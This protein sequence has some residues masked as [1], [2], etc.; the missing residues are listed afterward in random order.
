MRRAPFIPDSPDQDSS[1]RKRRKSGIDL[2]SNA[3][4]RFF[5]KLTAVVAFVAN[6]VFFPTLFGVFGQVAR[7][8]SLLYVSLAGL[9][10]GVVGG[11]AAALAGFL[12]NYTILKG[13]G[14]DLESAPV[15]VGASLVIGAVV[16]LLS[17]LSRRLSSEL[18][19]K[20]RVEEELRRYRNGLEELVEA[21]TE[22][23]KET[24][25]K[26]ELEVRERIEALKALHESEERFR[27]LSESTFEGVL[28]FRQQFC[29]E[30][31][32]VASA[33]LERPRSE[34]LGM[35]VEALFHPDSHLS[36]RALLTED[37][38]SPVEARALNGDGRAFPVEARSGRTY[39]NGEAVRVLALR[40]LSEREHARMA[41]AVSEENYRL[42]V[43]NTNEAIL[44]IQGGTIGFV[45]PAAA[46]LLGIPRKELISS[47]IAAFIHPE[48]RDVMSRRY[49][50]RRRGEPQ[51]ELYE[52]R[53]VD[54][55]G[56][57][58]WVEAKVVVI[59]WEG[60]EA[61]LSFVTDVTDRVLAQK[62]LHTSE[63]TARTL[64]NASTTAA[65]L[66]D[67]SGVLLAG[68]DRAFKELGKP[69][70]EVKGG[71]LYRFLPP[72][73]VERR[74]G[75]GRQVLRTGKPSRFLDEINGRFMDTSLYPVFDERRKVVRLA[76]FSTDI[77]ERLKSE[78]A[79]RQSEEKYSSVFST[80]PVWI[81]I[82]TIEEGRYVEVNE[83]FLTSTGY[84]REEVLGRTALELGMWAD[85]EDRNR[86]VSALKRDG[87]VRNVEVCR[88][89]KHG[90]LLQM[91]FF[92]D[93]IRIGD[94]FYMMSISLDITDRKRNEEERA[95]LEEQLLQAQKMEA[96]GV[97][98]GGIAHDFNNLLQSIRGYAELLLLDKSA[99][100]PGCRE[101]TEIIHSASRGADMV[102]QLLTFSRK[103]E[104]KLR[105]VDLNREIRNMGHVLDR[106]LH[107]M[108]R[109]SLHLAE[110][111][112]PIY[113]DPVQIEQVI[114]N[115]AV[116]ARDAMPHGGDLLIETLNVRLDA[117]TAARHPVLE[118][119][120]YVRLRIS[121][122]GQGMTTET[123]AH[124]F[125]PFYSTKGPGKG[126]GLG[127]SM[128]YGIIRNHG[129]DISC[130]SDPER[131]TSFHIY[132]RV[133]QTGRL[134]AEEPSERRLPGGSETILLVD[135]EESI[136]SLGAEMLTR[137]GYNVIAVEDGE[138]AIERF[139]SSRNS[140]DLV[141]LDLM[142]PGIGG[143]K[144]LETLLQEAPSTRVLI[145]TGYPTDAERR[146][147]LAAGAKAFIGK[148][149]VIDE[150]LEAV[151]NV[152]DRD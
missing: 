137:F 100:D 2:L 22:A 42:V 141:I 49:D 69:S 78:E 111:L 50:E 12:S 142:M 19:E 92:A 15:G 83:A 80:A 7:A 145:T 85:N 106:T 26:L 36:V 51:P 123:E 116:N 151:R 102:K 89:T 5:L 91:L 6:F 46:R 113:A 61:T 79:I 60:R 115:L 1:V 96:V 33:L 139:R 143:R 45:N 132:L 74:L 43:E 107:K 120:A 62:A 35:N 58:R 108:I 70:Y 10:W 73:L 94:R 110:D 126:T 128:V 13:M 34:L 30:A 8:F 47:P 27:C 71:Y 28:F 124:L 118:P 98:A 134:P 29:M 140:V 76:L 56:R 57:T 112:N 67:A 103:V 88:K 130:Y 14:A 95:R 136:R 148:P 53:L 84:Q 81:V 147:M 39:L 4:L 41:L 24:N 59:P 37:G 138:S 101:L 117:V 109:V 149:Y 119:G 48:D 133:A 40:D 55:M 64:L 11:T 16:G 52:C 18:F 152:L 131:G 21:R 86:I 129:G 144:C 146:D 90:T 17:D 54:R 87:S 32:S 75:E 121:D 38:E 114:M 63:E 3:R 9:A 99:G 127:L 125:E 66:L 135:D 25:R 93:K 105:P 23:L 122:T 97:L 104:S 31:N 44:V 77:T 150:L 20:E 68:N 72:E 65:F 82:S